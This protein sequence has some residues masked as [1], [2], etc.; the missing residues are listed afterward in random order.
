MARGKPKAPKLTG[1]QAIL[2]QLAALPRNSKLVIEGGKR[3]LGIYIREN[4]QAVQPQ[5]AL[6]VEA[7]SGFVRAVQVINPIQSSDDGITEALQSLVECL[8]RPAG[9]PLALARPLPSPEP[10]LPEKIV[11]NDPALAEAAHNLFA[12]LEIPVEYAEHLP[13]F[14]EAFRD[15]SAALGAKGDGGEGPPEPF[16][17][18]TDE[19]LLPSLYKAAGSYWRRA[20]WDYLGSDVPIAIELGQHGPQPGV[21]TL[22]A[23]V[24]GNAGE[25]FGAAF[26]YS[27][28]AFERTL[29]QGEERMERE[30]A[31]GAEGA[32]GAIDEQAGKADQ[33]VDEL[34]KMMRQ[35]GAPVDD[36]PPEALRRMLASMMEAQGLSAEDG[37]E[38]GAGGLGSVGGLGEGEPTDEEEYLEAIEDSLLLYFDPEDASDPTYLDWLAGR[39][40][41]YASREAVPSFHRLVEHSGPVRPSDQEVKA[42]T[43]AIEALNQFFSAHRALLDYPDMGVY[44][45][46]M[47]GRLSY[48]AH[49]GEAKAKA[50]RLAVKISLPPEGYQW[51][52]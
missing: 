23:V 42:L 48:T 45:L 37:E 14:E 19:D 25:V 13:N 31:E 21:E 3:P 27:L 36:V 24:L 22:Y 44:P 11:V 28:E 6:W 34:I 2:A 43:L 1:T 50:D 18:E 5:V 40:L 16:E 33:R 17:W 49:I 51:G 46:M 10:G 52:Y 35:A 41:K 4:K 7:G 32:E 26:Y 38:E 29:Q 47:A 39:K 8:A 12:P 20:P 30:E 9:T 15:M